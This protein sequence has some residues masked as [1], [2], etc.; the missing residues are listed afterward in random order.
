MTI[1]VVLIACL[2]LGWQNRATDAARNSEPTEV[3]AP[4]RGANTF[5]QRLADLD[6]RVAQIRT[7]KADFEQTKSTPLLKKPLVS[8]GSIVV[9]GARAKWQTDS[10][11]Q[12]IM[13]FGG[14]EIRMYYPEAR[15]VEI[16]PLPGEFQ[17]FAGNPL[18]RLGGLR[19]KFKVSEVDPETMGAPPARGRFLGV[20]LSP[21]DPDL[22]EHISDIRVLIDTALPCISR[23][24]FTDPD[25][26]RTSIVM[27]NVRV[28]V[29]VTDEEVQPKLPAGT[30]ESRPLPG[31]APKST[32]TGAAKDSSK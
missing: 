19:S 6:A 5:D 11:R 31:S 22:K 18:P 9:K 4:S 17:E 28:D 8:N 21:S 24:E 27:S 2:T 32:S 7:L 12:M 30:R 1:A 23:L 16:Y 10:P 20:A 3:A 14:G 25:G 13:T 26:A 29:D 15:V